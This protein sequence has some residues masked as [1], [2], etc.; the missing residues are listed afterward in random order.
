MAIQLFALFLYSSLCITDASQISEGAAQQ[1]WQQ[2][3]NSALQQNGIAADQADEMPQELKDHLLNKAE[4]IWKSWMQERKGS[5]PSSTTAEYDEPT[6]T[7]NYAMERLL[8]G[9][10]PGYSAPVEQ[11]SY[12][13]VSSAR[14]ETSTTSSSTT[15][16]VATTT[17]DPKLQIE[18][19]QQQQQFLEIRKSFMH[20][21]TAGMGKIDEEDA[22]STTTTVVTTT[23]TTTT[24]SALS[25][26]LEGVDRPAPVAPSE[27]QTTTTTT[28]TTTTTQTIGEAGRKTLAFLESGAGHFVMPHHHAMDEQAAPEDDDDDKP[29]TDSEDSDDEIGAGRVGAEFDMDNAS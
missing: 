12:R 10:E 21:L 4:N 1:L 15:T 5:E 29:K 9:V 23:T 18:K 22:T 16:T 6:T 7:V 20:K 8:A 14:V 26:L 11:Q 24:N 19:E 2:A 27:K 17:Q 13:Q 25:K 3:W 28:S